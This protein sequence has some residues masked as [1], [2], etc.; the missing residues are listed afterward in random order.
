MSNATHETLGQHFR[1]PAHPDVLMALGRT[2][3]NFLAL[4]E[5]VVAILFD[6]GA[7]NL[8]ETRALMAG[9]K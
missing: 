8:S 3:Y 1:V 2:I 7:A 4:E 5:T 6:A 9:E